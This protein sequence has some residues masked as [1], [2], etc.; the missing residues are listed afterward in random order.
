M[1]YQCKILSRWNIFLI[2]C[3]SWDDF[4]CLYHFCCNRFP[5]FMF[6]C[7]ANLFKFLLAF[8]HLIFISAFLD[9]LRIF[10]MIYTFV[11]ACFINFTSFCCFYCICYSWV[12]I[13][14]NF[15]IQGDQR[16][17]FLV[18]KH[19]CSFQWVTH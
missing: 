3:M 2:I 11:L 15:Y 10:T 19:L 6:D 5:F 9:N 17:F 13:T 18:T 4:S 8:P 16:L 12:F 7:L 14:R 1:I